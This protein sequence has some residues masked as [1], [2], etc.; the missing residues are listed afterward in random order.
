MK[1]FRAYAEVMREPTQ[2]DDFGSERV[3]TPDGRW[4]TKNFVE[5]GFRADDRREALGTVVAFFG[6]GDDLHY[7]DLEEVLAIWHTQLPGDDAL[8]RAGECI[9]RGE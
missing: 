6:D 4:M 3:R 7:V 9:W 2:H 8:W 5:F 1:S